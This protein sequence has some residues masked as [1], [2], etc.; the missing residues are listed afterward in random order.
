MDIA[1]FYLPV[2]QTNKKWCWCFFGH[3]TFWETILYKYVGFRVPKK[4]EKRNKYISNH[5]LL[6][7]RVG[8]Q[9]QKRIIHGFWIIRFI[10]YGTSEG[11]HCSTVRTTIV[12]DKIIYQIFKVFV[13]IWFICWISVQT[14]IKDF[15]ELNTDN[16]HPTGV[17]RNFRWISR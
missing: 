15:A 9:K 5:Q 6:L 3:L 7:N 13:F 10:M 8:R 12:S 11:V 1:Y 4:E 2:F 14:I 16:L 17:I